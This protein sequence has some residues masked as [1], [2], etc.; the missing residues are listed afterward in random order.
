MYSFGVLLLE[1][2]TGLKPIEVQ[3]S[4]GLLSNK[5]VNDV[6]EAYDMGELLQKADKR[7]NGEFDKGQMERVLVVGLLCVQEEREHRPKIRNA[8]NLLSD[9]SHPVPQILS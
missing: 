4:G 3:G 5:L 7:L 1:I 9:L 6:R 2:A 8:V